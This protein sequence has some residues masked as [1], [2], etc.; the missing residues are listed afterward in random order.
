M[1]CRINLRR[2]GGPLGGENQVTLQEHNK[3]P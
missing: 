1:T 2:L 3:Q